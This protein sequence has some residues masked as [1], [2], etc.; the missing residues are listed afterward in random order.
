LGSPATRR[1]GIVHPPPRRSL[2]DRRHPSRE[3]VAVER[4]YGAIMSNSE[5]AIR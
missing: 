3:S 5:L 1:F 4:L 2:A